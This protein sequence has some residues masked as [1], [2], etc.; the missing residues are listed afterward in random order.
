VHEYLDRFAGYD[1]AFGN[2]DGTCKNT[3][4]TGSPRAKTYGNPMCDENIRSQ[5]QELLDAHQQFKTE[6]LHQTLEPPADR[7]T[8]ANTPCISQEMNKITGQFSDSGQGLLGQLTGLGGGSSGDIM[9]GFMNAGLKSL[10]DASKIMP[11]MNSM[12]TEAQSALQ[13]VINQ[14]GSSLG[15]SGE[16]CGLMVDTVMKFIQC[17]MPPIQLPSFDLSLGGASMNLQLPDNCAGKAAQKAIYGAA[18][19]NVGTSLGQGFS[20]SGGKLTVNPPR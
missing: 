15:L 14:I 11:A 12:Q 4:F 17:S 2:G 10:M 1:T 5:I 18:N 16:V 6:K 20:F 7:T 19:S 9:S 13:G 3:P 8:I